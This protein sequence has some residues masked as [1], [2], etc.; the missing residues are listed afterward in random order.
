MRL[1]RRGLPLGCVGAGILVG[2]CGGVG[3]SATGR[4]E[5]VLTGEGTSV[6]RSRSSTGFSGPKQS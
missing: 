5:T 4:G 1:A 3:V 6:I 2:V